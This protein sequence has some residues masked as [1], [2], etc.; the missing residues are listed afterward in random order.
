MWTWAAASQRGTSHEKTGTGK[1]DAF[2]CIAAGPDD[3]YLIAIACDG[4]GSASHG[5]EGACLASRS[6]SQAAKLLISNED[7][8]PNDDE[9]QEWI[10]AVRDQIATVAAR[11][12]LSSRDF[13]TTLAGVIS[14]GTTTI[15]FHIGDGAIVTRLA[16][17]GC[18]EAQSWPEHGEYASTTYF[19]TDDNGARLRIQKRDAPVDRIAAFTDGIERLALDFNL[20]EPHT[21]F[22]SGISEPV[23]R[24]AAIGLDRN[25]SVKLGQ[26]LASDAINQRTDDDKTLIL[27]SL[28]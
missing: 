2:R 23:A 19:V 12:E 8:F 16:E 20:R 3:R 28:R 4:A 21:P 1:Q 10:D 11:N 5:G 18:W 26:Y 24:S 27:A 7:R 6:I 14:D 25:L 9:I 22:F 15:S 17:N 13:A